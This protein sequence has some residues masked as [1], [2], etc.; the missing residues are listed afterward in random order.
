MGLHHHQCRPGISP[1]P[2]SP[3]E[4]SH[5]HTHTHTH[6]H[7]N[8]CYLKT[9]L[10]QGSQVSPH[11]VSW[12][13][14]RGDGE[15]NEFLGRTSVHSGMLTLFRAKF[16]RCYGFTSLGSGLLL[17]LRFKSKG[18][19]V[20]LLSFYFSKGLS[21]EYQAITLTRNVRNPFS[22]NFCGW[23][24]SRH[25]HLPLK[26]LFFKIL[27]PGNSNANQNCNE[28]SSH[29]GRNGHQPKAMNS[30]C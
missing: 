12:A 27:I 2:R 19:P 4:D 8:G 23:Y 3:Q 26:E 13:L 20:F 15:K 5:T 10:H 17:A 21:K 16:R 6:T 25:P 14:V 22:P 24:P 11:L 1:R 18:F 28:I 9:H 29:T 7:P 30:K